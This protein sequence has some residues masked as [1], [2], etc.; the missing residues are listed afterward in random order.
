MQM[1]K[2]LGQALW[3]ATMLTSPLVLILAGGIVMAV[4]ES[5]LAQVMPPAQLE[6]VNQSGETVWITPLSRTNSA[7]YREVPGQYALT[8]P[9][10]PAIRQ[11]GFR[12]DP[13]ASLRIRYDAAYSN[14]SE[15]VVGDAAGSPRALLID[16]AVTE[17]DILTGLSERFEIP[18]LAELPEPS[19]H[20]VAAA[21]EG[22]FNTQG[23]GWFSLG[24]VPV[25]F[26]ILYFRVRLPRRARQSGTEH[27]APTQAA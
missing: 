7:G 8:V 13:G 12:L 6:A 21:E 25:I 16:R 3:L 2:R 27:A 18:P 15:I 9:A 11:G 23:W 4:G 24:F 14:P 19:V 5:I 26:L 1:R 10:I 22:R 20:V 17:M